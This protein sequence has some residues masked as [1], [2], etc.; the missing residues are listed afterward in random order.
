[1]PSYFKPLAA[2]LLLRT[3]GCKTLAEKLLLLTSSL[4]HPKRLNGQI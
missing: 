2:K 4:R 3:T 1:M